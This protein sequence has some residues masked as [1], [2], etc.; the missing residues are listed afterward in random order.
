LQEL[1]EPS[2]IIVVILNRYPLLWLSRTEII[3]GVKLTDKMFSNSSE[4]G[5]TLSVEDKS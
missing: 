5:S 4:L 2:E 1:F 3:E